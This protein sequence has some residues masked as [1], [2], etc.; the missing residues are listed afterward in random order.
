[1]SVTGIAG[2]LQSTGA[3]N[4]DGT[5]A[6]QMDPK[7]QYTTFVIENNQLVAA[8]YH[9]TVIENTPGS[10]SGQFIVTADLKNLAG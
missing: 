2:V 4:E 10:K 3:T 7:Q 8:R 1:M 6:T 9:S 5:P